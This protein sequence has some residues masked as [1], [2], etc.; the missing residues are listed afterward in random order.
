MVTGL[1][2]VK[3]HRIIHLQVQEGQLVE[4]GV[5][6]PDTVKWLPIDKFKIFD[7]G[8]HMYQDYMTLSFDNRKVNID[9][10]EGQNQEVV[11]GKENQLGYFTKN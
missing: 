4:H 6:K 9:Q 8:V 3:E 2:L 5:I 10:L 11:T 1:K 7:A